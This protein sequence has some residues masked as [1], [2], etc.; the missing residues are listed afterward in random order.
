MTHL[1]A[2]IRSVVKARGPSGLIEAVQYRLVHRRLRSARVVR[3]LVANKAGLE[4]GGPTA[5]FMRDGLLP[6]YGAVGALD[7]VNFSH[8]TVWEGSIDEGPTYVYDARRPAGTQFI[9]E[10]SDLRRIPAERYDFVLSSHT[11]EHTANPLK[12]L[13]EWI[14]VLKN[15]GVLVLVLP[16]KQ[17]TFDHRRPVTALAHLVDDERRGTSEDDVTH[18]AEILALHDLDRDHAAG[19]HASFRARSERN[20][21]NRCLHHHVF[22]TTLAVEMVNLVGMQVLSVEAA[23]VHHIFVIAKKPRRGQ[24]ADN[25]VFLGPNAAYRMRSPFSVD[26]A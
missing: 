26:R 11:L 23:P 17:G 3:R 22:D 9:L 5:L 2:R 7:N 12:A 24:P 6:L 15:E 1:L 21:E 25:T 16:H 14:R 10:A 18:L 20:I 4:L 13:R 19:D 8:R